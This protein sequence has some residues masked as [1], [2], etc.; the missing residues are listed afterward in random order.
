M[1]TVQKWKVQVITNKCDRMEEAVL[2]N[3]WFRE[4]SFEIS[5][6]FNFHIKLQKAVIRQIIWHRSVIQGLP[7]AELLHC[8]PLPNC[9]LP[10]AIS[11]FIYVRKMKWK[12]FNSN[13]LPPWKDNAHAVAVNPCAHRQNGGRSIT[14]ITTYLKLKWLMPG[15]FWRIWSAVRDVRG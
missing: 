13:T 3:V 5:E 14:N 2:K 8:R 7:L 4:S 1:A 10:I 12:I 9:S 6:T 11:N 15:G